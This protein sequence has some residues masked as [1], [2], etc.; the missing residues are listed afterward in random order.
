MIIEPQ[1]IGHEPVVMLQPRDRVDEQRTRILRDHA[2]VCRQGTARARLLHPP[3]QQGAPVCYLLDRM[4]V[5][6]I[7]DA[8]LGKIV[9]RYRQ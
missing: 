1:Q 4:N 7:F 6:L 3:A 9:S 5:H 2:V 8:S